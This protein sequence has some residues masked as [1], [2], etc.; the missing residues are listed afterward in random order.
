[1]FN[2]PNEIRIVRLIVVACCG[3][4]RWL[5]HVAKEKKRETSEKN[6]GDEQ[7]STVHP[8]SF[9]VGSCGSPNSKGIVAR[10]VDTL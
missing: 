9:D 5:I 3:Y 7:I 10:S 1:M 6:L 4:L 2:L 8:K